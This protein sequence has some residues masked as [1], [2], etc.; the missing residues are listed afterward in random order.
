MSWPFLL[1]GRGC[2]LLLGLFHSS[3]NSLFG[4]A[5]T[6][7]VESFMK[8]RVACLLLHTASHFACLW[9]ILTLPFQHLLLQKPS[10][11]HYHHY[12]MY[13]LAFHHL[14]LIARVGHYPV[15][16]K[17]P[18]DLYNTISSSYSIY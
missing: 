5:Q 3:W 8:T 18:T 16:R 6:P 9:Q 13:L 10:A 7:P 14:Q 17:Y 12:Q 4:N 1:G 11:H 15:V 2:S